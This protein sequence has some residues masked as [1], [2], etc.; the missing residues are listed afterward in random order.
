MKRAQQRA[1]WK[2]RQRLKSKLSRTDDDSL[3]C[4]DLFGDGDSEKSRSEAIRK[5][6][7]SACC[8]AEG[9]GANSNS[10]ETDDKGK[11]RSTFE[12]APEWLKQK[13]CL[14]RRQLKRQRSI[15]VSNW[16]FDPL[17][18]RDKSMSK[19]AKSNSNSRLSLGASHV[20]RRNRTTVIQT[21][22]S[23]I[24]IAKTKGVNLASASTRPPTSFKGLLNVLGKQAEKN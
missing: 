24:V 8:P 21:S 18:S 14:E 1:L 12:D 22:K 11:K 9:V 19:P 7:E 23:N 16:S 5:R 3:G 10:N 15:A 2:A 4:L 13:A 20:I 17:G 6:L